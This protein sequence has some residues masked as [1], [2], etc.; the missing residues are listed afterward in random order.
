[1]VVFHVSKITE[2]LQNRAKCQKRSKSWIREVLSVEHNM[3]RAKNE[4]IRTY[5]CLLRRLVGTTKWVWMRRNILGSANYFH[6]CI[7]VYV[8][9]SPSPS[10][11]LVD[12]SV[13]K[14]FLLKFSN[15]ITY[16]F[17]FLLQYIFGR[18]LA[19]HIPSRSSS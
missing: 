17:M 7:S 14:V 6:F 11:P 1:M 3:L 15:Q 2:V 5:I 12:Y 8:N 4:D 9:I 16:G 13:S 19:C 18:V 10:P